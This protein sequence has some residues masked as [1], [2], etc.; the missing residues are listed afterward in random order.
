MSTPPV[1]KAKEIRWA[2]AIQK[3][4]AQQKV[5]ALATRAVSARR[6]ARPAAG[7][8]CGADE[9]IGKLDRMHQPERGSLI[10]LPPLPS[11][12]DMN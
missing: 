9:L 12:R 10:D 5:F 11:R 2:D 6:H 3:T 8:H 1:T 7:S 4:R